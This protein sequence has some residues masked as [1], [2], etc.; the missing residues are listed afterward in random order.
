[1]TPRSSARLRLGSLPV[2][3]PDVASGDITDL[4]AL[5][6][7]EV[8][9][10]DLFR[11]RNAAHGEPR[12]SLYG[13]QVAG[14]ALR[15]AGDRLVH[16]CALTYLSDLSSGFGQVQATGFP[17]GGPSIDHAMWFP[18]RVRADDWVLL[19]LWPSKAGGARGVYLGCVRDRHGTLGAMLSQEMLLRPQRS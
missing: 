16:A 14:Q 13:G 17:R 18:D 4:V 5:L 15:A 7:L 10:R 1:M 3:D 2:S 9:D 6:D 12:A 19:D 8:L 11:R